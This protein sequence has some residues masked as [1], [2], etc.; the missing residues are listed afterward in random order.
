MGI[1]ILMAQCAVMFV[2]SVF[3]GNLPMMFKSAMTGQQFTW[4]APDD[5]EAA[6][7]TRLKAISVF[8]MGILV[9]AALAIIIP[10]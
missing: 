3:A 10:E 2:A 9:G 7:G 1:L 4:S 8:G 6:T 5:A